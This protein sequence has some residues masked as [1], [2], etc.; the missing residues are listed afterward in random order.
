MQQQKRIKSIEIF[1]KRKESTLKQL[2]KVEEKLQALEN[3]RIYE[4][5]SLAMKS[6]LAEKDNHQLEQAFLKIAME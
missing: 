3:K 5:G 6:G 4:L 1:K 2:K